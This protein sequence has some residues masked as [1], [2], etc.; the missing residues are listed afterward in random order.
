MLVSFIHL[1]IWGPMFAPK[2]WLLLQ[3]LPKVWSYQGLLEN[4]KATTNTTLLSSESSGSAERGRDTVVPLTSEIL[5]NLP[6]G[7][8]GKWVLENQV[9]YEE[10]GQVY[11]S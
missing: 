5:P 10:M 11:L 7:W 1:S 3:S 8:G 4:I 6:D 2:F 9:N